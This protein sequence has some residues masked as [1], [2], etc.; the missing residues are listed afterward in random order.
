MNGHAG[1]RRRNYRTREYIIT[2][3]ICLNQFRGQWI[4]LYY[5]K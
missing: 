1:R 3:L 4:S 2:I 5:D